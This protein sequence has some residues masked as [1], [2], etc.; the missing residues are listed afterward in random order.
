MA[1][2]LGSQQLLTKSGIQ[3]NS[4]LKINKNCLKKKYKKEQ[5]SENFHSF[6]YTFM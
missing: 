4:N 5:E 3:E 1:S 6:H 2:C